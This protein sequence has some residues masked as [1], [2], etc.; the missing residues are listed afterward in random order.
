MFDFETCIDTKHIPY[1]VFCYNEKRRDVYYGSDCGKQLLDSINCDTILV[2][3]NASYDYH[4]LVHHLQNNK[5][6]SRGN[7]LIVSKSTYNGHEIII[8]D[9]YKLISSPLRD[10]P[11]Y[12]I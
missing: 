3:H 10:F 6:L 11:K 9:S 4:F 7:N 12:S 8:K 1:L 5:E 2:T